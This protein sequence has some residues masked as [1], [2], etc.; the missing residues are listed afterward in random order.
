MSWRR[1]L[2]HF[3]L[4]GVCLLALASLGC[5]DE[6]TPRR[7]PAASRPSPEQSFQQI[8]AFVKS[9]VETGAGAM[10]SGF[11]TERP[12]R[13]SQFVVHNEVTSQFIPPA[14]PEEASRGIITVTS[15]SVYS[16]RRSEQPD[17]A[18][19]N[20][21][22]ESLGDE[23]DLLDDDEGDDSGIDVFD[24]DL[25]AALPRNKNGPKQ[26]PVTVVD[27]KEDEN[28]RAFEFAFENERWMLKTEPDPATEQAIK[29][30]FE[31][32]LSLQP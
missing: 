21:D 5:E 11:V 16:L 7:N 1:G 9:R 3:A 25:V 24:G 27:R 30:A 28:V 20:R 32:A 4:G 14:T 2:T 26:V 19:G 17:D 23:F 13:R 29:R 12:G 31:R 6:S 8:V 10:P 15:R 22:G 18:N